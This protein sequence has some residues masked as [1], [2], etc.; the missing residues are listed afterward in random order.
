[1]K[2][3]VCQDNVRFDRYCAEYISQLSSLQRAKKWIKEGNILLNGKTA[4]T[5]RFLKKGDVLTITL[6][7]SSINTWQTDIPVHFEDSHLAIVYKPAG[8]HVSGNHA[9]TLRK[10]LP[11]NL[12][13]S[14]QDDALPQPEPIHRIDR[15]TRGLIAVAKTNKARHKLGLL[16]EER[17]ITKKYYALCL[18]TMTDGH[19]ETSIDG[20]KAYT[21]WKVLSVHRSH[22]TSSI[23]LVE[24]TIT[25]G[26][27]H[28]IRRHTHAIGHPILG[29]DLYCIGAPL[30]SKG[31]F[32]FA[33]HL[34]FCHPITA[35]RLCVSLPIP[36]KIHRRID[37]EK[38]CLLN[39]SKNKDITEGQFLGDPD[40][41]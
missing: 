2:L 26:R 15:R 18:G 34:E 32:L 36:D 23:S 40:E 8:I 17:K 37:Y 9:K 14:T 33:H 7:V 16:L 24:C 28:Q 30:R 10:A 21:S 6:P 19:S 3:Q 12:T 31:L 41:I 29:D 39:L 27:R 1:M 13:L 38:R 22:F 20:K 4:E 5:S 11:C 25:T 35:Q